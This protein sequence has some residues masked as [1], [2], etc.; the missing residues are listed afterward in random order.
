MAHQPT[1]KQLRYLHALAEYRHFGQAARAC[2]V[3]Q[4]TLSSAIQ[5]LEKLLEVPLLERGHRQILL[6]PVGEEVVARGRRILASV[7]EL[8]K[9]CDAAAKPLGG[10]MRLGVIPT[11]APYL[12]PRLLGGLRSRFPDF[13]LFIREDLSDPLV[14]ALHKGELDVLLLALPF[15]ADQTETTTLFR[16]PFHLACPRGHPLSTKK[17][18]FTRDLVGQELLLLEDGHCLRSHALEACKLR[19]ME[20]A[21]PY[22]AT[23]LH[24][25][26]QMVANGIGITL[27][28]EMALEARVLAGT[29]VVTR[30]FSG[31]S[32]EREIGLMWRR[33]AARISEFELLA[34]HIRETLQSETLVPE[35]G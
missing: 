11:I 2:H 3:S 13:Q 5:D 7:E 35:A 24:T 12:L 17:Q 31:D 14:E 29:D 1:L 19:D 23:S 10:R 4:S 33:R 27:L 22:Q 20:L 9:L 26:V 28:P 8:T 16:D 18:V 32:V 6:T 25:L 15:P 34:E 21:V 30:P